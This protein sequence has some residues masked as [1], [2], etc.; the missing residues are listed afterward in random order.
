MAKKYYRGA[1]VNHATLILRLAREYPDGFALSCSRRSLKRILNMIPD[2][3]DPRVCPW[4][5]GSRAGI[6]YRER[7]AW[8]PV[9]VCG[10]RPRRRGPREVL[11]DVLILSR[12]TRQRIHDD[13]LV[14]MKPAGFW[15]WL[16]ELLGAT[17]GDR[18]EELFRGSG[19]GE[20]AWRLFTGDRKATTRPGAP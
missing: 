10:G 13:A 14:G 19:A 4:V 2:A 3:L 15:S 5:N 1:E 11:D 12:N 20:R 6:S 18:F 9:I 16:F 7:I 17:R 8:E